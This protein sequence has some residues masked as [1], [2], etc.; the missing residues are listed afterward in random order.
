MKAKAVLFDLD[1][2]LLDTIEDLS[3]SMNEVLLEL[4]FPEHDIPS[5]KLFVG[6][7]IDSLA[8]RVL[9]KDARD[10]ATTEKCVTMMREEY[11]KRWSKKTRPYEG[12]PE[13]LRYLKN[14]GIPMAVLSNKPDDFTILNIKKFLFEFRFEHVLGAQPGLPKKPDPRGALDI[15]NRLKIQ[16]QAFLYLGDTGT[17]MKTA[18]AAGMVP[19]GVLWGFRFREELQENGAKVLISHPEDLIA[20]LA[21][22]E[23]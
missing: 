1:G 12:I 15:S 3:D 22:H 21:A 6:E 13:L 17:D 2:T 11:K 19:V 8:Y 4:G 18:V 9:P 5:Y 23:L 14:L 7:G 16:P 10:K 20:L